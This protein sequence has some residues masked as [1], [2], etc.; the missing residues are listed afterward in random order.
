MPVDSVPG[1]IFNIVGKRC[2]ASTVFAWQVVPRQANRFRAQRTSSRR[3]FGKKPFQFL[4]DTMAGGVPADFA[5]IGKLLDL[6]DHLFEPG[7]R[8]ARATRCH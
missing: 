5:D 6:A 2:I 8:R 3:L 4:E 7:G 1:A